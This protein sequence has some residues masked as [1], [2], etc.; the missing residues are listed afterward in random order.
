VAATPFSGDPAAAHCRRIRRLSRACAV[1]H[2][3][4]GAQSWF[5]SGVFASPPNTQWRWFPFSRNITGPCSGLVCPIFAT[6]YGVHGVGA[7]GKLYHLK[8][9]EVVNIIR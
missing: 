5:Y 3:E 7:A 6:R 9:A 8:T 1:S 2:D 4:S